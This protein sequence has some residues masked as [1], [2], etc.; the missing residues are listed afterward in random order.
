LVVEVKAVELL[1]VEEIGLVKFE[2]NVVFIGNLGIGVDVWRQGEL[3]DRLQ[4]DRGRAHLADKRPAD[5]HAGRSQCAGDGFS[6][7]GR[8]QVRDVV[9][10]GAD[11]GEGL[12]ADAIGQGEGAKPVGFARRPVVVAGDRRDDRG[13]IEVEQHGVAAQRQVAACDVDGDI[14]TAFD[15][16]GDHREGGVVV[17]GSQALKF[18]RRHG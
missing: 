15:Q 6:M 13:L 9:D 8:D 2:H 7:G 18:E 5:G 16:G 3:R 4:N 1:R 17:R 10:I 11:I 12:D 14:V